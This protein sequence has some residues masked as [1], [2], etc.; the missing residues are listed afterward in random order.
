MFIKSEQQKNE[1]M[2]WNVHC[3]LTVHSE[4]EFGE[5]VVILQSKTGSRTLTF[6][7]QYIV[8]IDVEHSWEHLCKVEEDLFFSIDLSLYSLIKTQPILRMKR[9]KLIFR[10][11]LHNFSL[12]RWRKLKRDSFAWNQFATD[13]DIEACFHFENNKQKHYTEH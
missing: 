7:S 1:V 8:S 11:D 5:F 13:C 12:K 6:L 2:R 9:I 3:L 10:Y 4:R